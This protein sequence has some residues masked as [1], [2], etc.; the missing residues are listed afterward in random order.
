M[1]G[2][3][4]SGDAGPGGVPGGGLA[5]FGKTAAVPTTAAAAGGSSMPKI[6]CGSGPMVW[7][8]ITE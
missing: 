6:T 8:A 2:A 1:T 7:P 4:G 3:P 5:S